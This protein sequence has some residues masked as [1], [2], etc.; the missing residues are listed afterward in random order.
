MLD[1]TDRFVAVAP[2]AGIA[3]FEAA[4]DTVR[5]DPPKI[6][7][8][9]PQL[10]RRLSR[11]YLSAGERRAADDCEID[12]GAWRACDVGAFRL[13]ATLVMPHVNSVDVRGV[14]LE[15]H[16]RGDLEER[17][18]IL[19]SMAGLPLGPWTVD[20][21]GEVQRTNQIVHVAAAVLDSNLLVRAARAGSRGEIA[22]DRATIDRMM[23]KIAFLDLPLVRVFDGESCASPELS[24]M[25]L[26][27]AT[28][29]EAAGRPVW[30][31]TDRLLAAAPV[32]GVRARLIG[33]LEHGDDHRRLE[34]A[35]WVARTRDPALLPFVDDRLPR[36][37]HPRVREALLQAKAALE[38]N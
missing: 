31:D 7:Q 32:A 22:V 8:I 35:L 18:M 10:P 29:R 4:L 36:E 24:R 3:W 30:R 26:G 19:R 20:L 2:A 12:S 5:R 9:L 23:L 21:L 17:S 15:L 27:L 25:L 38:A 37:D 11:E 28:E 16:A 6:D 34:A 1:L 13:L 14:L 33:G